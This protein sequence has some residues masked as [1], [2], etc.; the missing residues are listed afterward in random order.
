[1]TTLLQLGVALNIQNVECTFV[2]PL[3]DVLIKLKATNLLVL[4]YDL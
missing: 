2:I 4:F 1:M 3:I